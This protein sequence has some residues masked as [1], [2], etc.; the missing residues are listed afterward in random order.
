METDDEEEEEEEED[1]KLKR[2]EDEWVKEMS[3]EAE[4]DEDEGKETGE[5]ESENDEYGEEEGIGRRSMPYSLVLT[6]SLPSTTA[7]TQERMREA[8]KPPTP[9][10]PLILLN[11]STPP[12][13][14]K[15]LEGGQA[16]VNGT[17][18]TP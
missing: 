14:L 8:S 5:G 18:G 15:S 7:F 13:V 1:G 2:C 6:G 4:E 16:G 11:S 12:I 3:E 9:S 10:L 17:A